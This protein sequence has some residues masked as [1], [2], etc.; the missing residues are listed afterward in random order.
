LIGRLFYS[1]KLGCPSNAQ[2]QTCRKVSGQSNIYAFLHD[3]L[4]YA[5][6]KVDFQSKNGK[7]LTI[8]ESLASQGI[9]LF[10]LSKHGFFIIAFVVFRL[11]FFECDGYKMVTV[12]M[13]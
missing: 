3:T 8:G 1:G 9:S 5:I 10:L 12:F 13:G 11:R 2:H 6:I 7:S 4:A